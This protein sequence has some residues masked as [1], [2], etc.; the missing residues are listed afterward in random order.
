MKKF[1]LNNGSVVVLVLLCVYYSIVTI[2]RQHPVTPAA[3]EEVAQAILADTKAPSVLIVTRDTDQDREFARAVRAV[4]EAGGGTIVDSVHGIA[5]DAGR[6][7]RTAGEAGKQVDAIA[8]HQPSSEWGPLTTER[9]EESRNEFRSLRGVKLYKPVS[10]VWPSF[11]TRPNLVNVVNQNADIA[12]IAIGMTLVIITAGIDLSVGSLV[13]VAGV[14]TAVT[15]QKWAGGA[16]AG[17]AGMIGCSLI[18]IGVCLLCGVFNGVMV[19]YFR[20]PAFVVT[21]G[22]MMVARGVALIIAVQ[23]QS[24]LLGGG[25]KGTP[26]A[27]KVE[28]IAW[29][30]LGNGS[31]LGVPNPIL[32]ML[33]LYIL[34]HLV[35]TRTSFGRYVYAVGGNP[36]AA[37]LSG[38][39][40]FAV[41][42]SVYAL[43]G[44]MAGLA[45]VIDASRFEGGRPIAG[46]LYELKV[47]AAVVVGGTSLAGGEGRI[48]GTLIGAMII[49][50]IENGLN[51][52]GVAS[53]EQKIVFGLLILVAVLLDRLKARD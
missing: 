22:I 12:I 7:I 21:L 10:Y 23:Y 4:I 29:P 32:L 17:A 43:C 2:G 16:D 5:I 26:E 40:V 25:T 8:T 33:V 15:I 6:A 37:R 34:A 51:M 53:Y 11:L 14:V 13:A 45:G 19:T 3:G 27:V 52:A 39:P 38:V 18:G 46:D 42:I 48:F 20:V 47:I 9:L 31:I 36:E 41:L 49:A 28:A 24:S 1:L 50:V 44:A 35:M 30:W